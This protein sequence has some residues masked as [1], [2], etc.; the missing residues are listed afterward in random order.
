MLL[1]SRKGII[2]VFPAMPSAWK[3][4]I[5]ENLRAEGAFLISG[6][7]RD[8]KADWVRV[9]SLAGE[10]CRLRIHF[11]SPPQALGNAAFAKGGD[12]LYDLP[13]KKGDEIVL[14]SSAAAPD[15]V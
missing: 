12:D 3:D 15:L 11:D 4:A 14:C 9:K 10:P 6:R 8:G 1:Q 2:R 13:L 5:F 7:W